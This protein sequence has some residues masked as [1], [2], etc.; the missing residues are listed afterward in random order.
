MLKRI[1]HLLNHLRDFFC[2]LFDRVGFNFG[3]DNTMKRVYLFSKTL[4]QKG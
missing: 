4:P 3:I 2:I 1:P